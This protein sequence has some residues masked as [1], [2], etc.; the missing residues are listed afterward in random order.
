MLARAAKPGPRQGEFYDQLASEQLRAELASYIAK[1]EAR[2]Q[3]ADVK[4]GLREALESD[5]ETQGHQNGALFPGQVARWMDLTS[6]VQKLSGS[7]HSRREPSGLA[8]ELI[9]PR[10]RKLIVLDIRSGSSRADSRPCPI[11]RSGKLFVQTGSASSQLRVQCRSANSHRVV[12][13]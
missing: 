3:E 6:H 9:F 1:E 11:Q 2:R 5:F 4:R 12:R 8:S 13:S 10:S 7:P